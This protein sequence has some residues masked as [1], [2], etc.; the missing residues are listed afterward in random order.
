[1]AKPG[2]RGA[3]LPG[4]GPNSRR[5][6]AGN[7][8]LRLFPRAVLDGL[9]PWVKEITVRRGETLFEPGDEIPY[10][11]FPLKGT[12]LS[13]ILPMDNGQRVEAATIGR[14]GVVGGFSSM[15]LKPAFAA[16]VVQISGKIARIPLS[17]LETA[18][19]TTPKLHDL[20][21]RYTDCFLAQLL[22]SVACGTLHPLEA[23]AARWLLM[24]HDRVQQD[25]L[26]L[27]QETMAE[28]LGVART[29]MTRIATALQKRGAISYKR[30]VLRIERRDVLEK[31][32]C[33]CY[34]AVRQHF[35]RVAPGLYPD[36]EL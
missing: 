8:L 31:A 6:P 16:G 17:R 3:G 20:F 11:Y 5:R 21:A 14:E 19:R 34:G 33:E 23:R 12:V 18:K 7:Q 4:G 36:A 10:V 15:G 32:A 1:V 25:E 26:P 29:Y 2:G 28:T 27:T 9:A 24:T 30:G 13:L 35:E 22:Q